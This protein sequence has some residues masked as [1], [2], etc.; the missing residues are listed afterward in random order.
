MTVHWERAPDPIRGVA[1]FEVLK[2]CALN[3][4]NKKDRGSHIIYEVKMKRC[5]Y[6]RRKIFRSGAQGVEGPG[7][8]FPLKF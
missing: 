1:G 6:R 2:C 3:I 7:T 4:S 8:C 5:I